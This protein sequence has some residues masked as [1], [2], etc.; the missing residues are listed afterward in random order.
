VQL[1]P[2]QITELFNRW[3]YVFTTLFS[4]FSGY[5]PAGILG[6]YLITFIFD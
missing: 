2:F 5:E 1:N 6:H 3:N 4:G